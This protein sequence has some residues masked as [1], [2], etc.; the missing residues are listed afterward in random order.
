MLHRFRFKGSCCD[1]LASPA[2]HSAITVC[3]FS[4]LI[5]AWNRFDIQRPRFSPSSARTPWPPGSVLYCRRPVNNGGQNMEA[6][7]LAVSS[8]FSNKEKQKWHTK[9]SSLLSTGAAKLN[10][11]SRRPLRQLAVPPCSVRQASLVVFWKRA[12]KFRP[13]MKWCCRG[14]CNF[15]GKLNLDFIIR[16]LKHLLH[17]VQ[18]LL[19]LAHF[20]LY[21][22]GNRG[23]N[24]TIVSYNKRNNVRMTTQHT[25]AAVDTCM[26]CQVRHRKYV[27]NDNTEINLT[28]E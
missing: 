17:F 22:L 28:T 8:G 11:P 10:Q 23:W 2:E 21:L 9:A 18:S 4:R 3:A 16:S 24:V 20:C 14:F 15:T 12:Q 5:I 19:C 1:A 26:A 6:A 25:G 7:T 27:Q 13:R